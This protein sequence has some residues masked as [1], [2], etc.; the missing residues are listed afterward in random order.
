VHRQRQR[1]FHH[2]DAV[3]H[4]L[5][6]LLGGTRAYLAHALARDAELA[7]EFL[8][9]DRLFGEPARLEDSPRTI[10][11]CA[12]WMGWKRISPSKAR[13]TPSCVRVVKNPRIC[14]TRLIEL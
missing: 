2:G 1:S 10:A 4:R 13:A 9:R 12:S 5:P 8:E 3:F 11:D 7:G 14:A 6:H